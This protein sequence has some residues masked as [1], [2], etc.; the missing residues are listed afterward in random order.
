MKATHGGVVGDF[1]RLRVWIWQVLTGEIP[2]PKTQI[3]KGGA[4]ET[5]RIPRMTLQRMCADET[6]THKEPK[7]KTSRKDAKP[8]SEIAKKS[9]CV[10]GDRALPLSDFVL[11]NEVFL[12][13]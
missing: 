13:K 3:P 11:R 7:T 4:A 1:V 9:S 5:Q 10:P 8:Q 6:R 2:N 12:V